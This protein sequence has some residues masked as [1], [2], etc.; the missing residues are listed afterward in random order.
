MYARCNEFLFPSFCKYCRP[1]FVWYFLKFR[2]ITYTRRIYVLKHTFGTKASFNF[3][4]FLNIT[5]TSGKPTK[6][7]KFFYPF[8]K[9]CVQ[10]SK[11]TFESSKKL[12]IR[13]ETPPIDLIIF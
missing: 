8:R 6:Y 4:P 12:L 3:P 5:Y 11:T 2:K 1:K 9:G 7:I 10:N 13:L